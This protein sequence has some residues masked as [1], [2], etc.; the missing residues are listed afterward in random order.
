M[1]RMTIEQFQEMQ[2]MKGKKR[3]YGN[4]KTTIIFKGKEVTFDSEKEAQ[5]AKHLELLERAGE[6]SDLQIQ[7][8]F[9]LIPTFKLNGKT[10]QSVKYR[11][12]FTYYD[13]TNDGSICRS[14]NRWV[15]EDVK[16]PITKK[17]REYVIKKKMM[18]YFHR[19][20]VK[21]I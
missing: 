16:S 18:A 4:H 17:N 19:I 10:Y 11:A 12:D 15:V 21:E 3:K 7:K 14:T 13:C 5:R 6:I 20:E 9:E 2:E 8:E 1:L